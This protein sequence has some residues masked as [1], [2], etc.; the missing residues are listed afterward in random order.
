MPKLL[1][2]FIILDQNI[3]VQIVH[4]GTP[5]ESTLLSRE[6]GIFRFPLVKEHLIRLLMK[7][8]CRRSCDGAQTLLHA[9]V[10]PKAHGTTG[11][12]YE[13]V[14][15]VIGILDNITQEIPQI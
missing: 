12:Y 14:Q 6:D 1:I 7:M 8:F 4:P 13:L 5:V 10:D 15:L 2:F 11:L 3:T 9:V